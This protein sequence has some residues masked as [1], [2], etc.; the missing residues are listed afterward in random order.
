MTLSEVFMI[1]LG[2]ALLFPILGIF[3]FLLF[4]AT[5][6][7][8]HIRKKRIRRISLKRDPLSSIKDHG[9]PHTG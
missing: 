7:R 3:A 9:I 1:V 4:Q 6:G 2:G 8:D 5:A